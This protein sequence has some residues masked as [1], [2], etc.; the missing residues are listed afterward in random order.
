MLTER[1]TFKLIVKNISSLSFKSSDNLNG[2]NSWQTWHKSPEVAFNSLQWRFYF[3]RSV[4]DESV[5]LILLVC[6]A[7][8]QKNN[9]KLPVVHRMTTNTENDAANLIVNI[10]MP[11]HSMSPGP[12]VPVALL[13]IKLK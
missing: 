11:P 9:I 7:K 4:L 1:F 5:L 2:N 3:A 10:N 12:E 13:K 6:K 8:F